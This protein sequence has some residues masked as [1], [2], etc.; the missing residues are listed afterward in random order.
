MILAHRAAPI[1]I[2]STNLVSTTGLGTVDYLVTD[3]TIDPAGVNEGYYREKL[4]RLSNFNCYGAPEDCPDPAPLPALKN[5]VVT[6]GSFNNVAK[7]S[8]ETVAA[9]SKIPRRFPGPGSSSNIAPTTM[10]I[11]DAA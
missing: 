11:F 8:P 10:R 3:A 4:L 2:A 7:I 5:G 1:Q 6:F 9:W